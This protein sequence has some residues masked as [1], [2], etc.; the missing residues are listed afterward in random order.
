MATLLYI[1]PHPD[2]ESFGPGPGIVRQRREGHEVH[3][4]TLTRGG[5]TSQ[6]HRL[7]YTRAEMARMR[8]RQ[9]QQVAKILDLTSLTVLYYPDGGLAE[10]NPL[11]LE[12]EIT[13]RL[14]AVQP[15]VVITFPDHG[16]TGH[17]DHLVTHQIVKRAVCASKEDQVPS[18]QRLAFFTFPPPTDELTPPEDL[19]YSSRDRLDCVYPVEASDLDQGR[20]AL[21]HYVTYQ[22]DDHRPLTFFASGIPFEMFG[23]SHDPPLPSLLESL[24]VETDGRS[25]QEPCRC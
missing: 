6:R 1:F 5:A 13:D 3:L 12:T 2:D 9:M 20:K 19:Q 4:L 21:E 8:H 10:Q 11:R 14:H 18:P 23:E 24:S 17:P 16:I 25:R 22:P 7:G 15:D